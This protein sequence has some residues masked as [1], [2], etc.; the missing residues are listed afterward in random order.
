MNKQEMNEF[1]ESIGGLVNGW[2]RD[3]TPIIDAGFFSVG[4]GWYPLIKDLITDLIELGWNKEVC[5]VKEKFGGLR[6]YINAASDEMYDRISQAEKES[7]ETCEDTGQPGK[8]R[9]DLGWWVTLCDAE[10]E[11]RLAEKIRKQ[12]E[13]KQ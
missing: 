8:L 1:L 11:K 3:D 13:Q 5:Q 6:F 2:K 9:T 4:Y 7:Y 10:Y 12:I